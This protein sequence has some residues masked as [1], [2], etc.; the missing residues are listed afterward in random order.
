M[1]GPEE[2]EITKVH[3]KDGKRGERE[4]DYLRRRGLLIFPGVVL[5]ALSRMGAQISGLQ[6]GKW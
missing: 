2:A 5:V 1:S 4:S 6:E 3:R